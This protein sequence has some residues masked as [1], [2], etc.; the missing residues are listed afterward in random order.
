MFLQYVVQADYKPLIEDVLKISTVFVII[1]ILF[2]I[3]G[4][5]TTALGIDYIQLF[6]FVLLAVCTYWLV[7]SRLII[8]RADNEAEEN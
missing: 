3:N 7:V 1:H 2:M 5:D 4:I 8:I 6:V